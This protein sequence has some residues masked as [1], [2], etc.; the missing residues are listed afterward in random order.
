MITIKSVRSGI[1]YN[2]KNSSLF[3]SFSDRIRWLT[4]PEMDQIF[5]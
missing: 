1:I 5:L 2:I 3:V 4:D